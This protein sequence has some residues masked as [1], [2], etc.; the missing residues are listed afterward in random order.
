[1]ELSRELEPFWDRLVEEDAS[2]FES[3]VLCQQ[4]IDTV[5]RSA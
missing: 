3:I 1:M 4:V 5:R 2:S